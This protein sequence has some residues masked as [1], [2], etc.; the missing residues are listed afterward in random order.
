M[1]VRHHW[2]V[3]LEYCDLILFNT[4]LSLDFFGRSSSVCL[5]LNAKT[6]FF[7][8]FGQHP[9]CLL[10]SPV[11]LSDSHEGSFA[12]LRIRICL[13]TMFLLHIHFAAA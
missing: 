6:T 4:N 1:T 5:M 13:V 2:N 9:A 11:R 10:P 3:K 7:Q 12:L 8:T